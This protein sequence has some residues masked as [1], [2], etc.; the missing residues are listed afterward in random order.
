MILPWFFHCGR[1]SK[2]L[3]NTDIVK[4][5]TY[6]TLISSDVW[7]ESAQPSSELPTGI[8]N[9]HTVFTYRASAN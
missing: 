7:N 4:R 5:D 3:K 8:K 2:G 1:R 6:M 9:I